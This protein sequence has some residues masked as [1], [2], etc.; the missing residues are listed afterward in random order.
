MTYTNL[1]IPER[2]TFSGEA[3]AIAQ[4]DPV[5]VEALASIGYAAE[6][7]AHGATLEQAAREL[8]V[9]QDVEYVTRLEMSK[10]VA[11]M[12]KTLR[13]QIVADR[14]M[15]R[16]ALRSLEGRY[17]QL[18]M[19]RNLNRKRPAFM[20]QARN[21]YLE[22]Q[23]HPD[24]INALNAVGVP[25]ETILARLAFVAEF[26]GAMELQQH[27]IAEAAVATRRRQE[28]MEALDKWMVKFLNA[29][30]YVFADD[31]DQLKKIGLPI[32]RKPKAAEA[33]KGDSTP[34]GTAAPDETTAS[35]G[36][37]TP[38]ESTASNGDTAPGR[39]VTPTDG[40]APGSIVANEGTGSAS[41]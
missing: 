31:K 25:S 27:Q 17:D 23:A 21:I 11:D 9:N 3:L 7:L 6:D 35:G 39:D 30:R 16:T 41:A 13:A 34:D 5:L 40:A 18:R 10:K 20:Q 36:E 4:T 8:R 38:G 26:A 28:A 12:A 14:S 1:N 19:S 15:V 33:S 32:R 2:L 22:I 29:A 37:A 24:V